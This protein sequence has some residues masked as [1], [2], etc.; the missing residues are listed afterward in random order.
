LKKLQRTIDHEVDFAGVGINSGEQATITIRPAEPNTGI[1]FVRTDL[2]GRP[3]VPAK[4]ENAGTRPFRTSLVKDGVEVQMVEH[5][6]AAFAGMNIH[7][8]I[9]EINAPEV[10]CGDGSAAVFCEMLKNAGAVEQPHPRPQCTVT[11]PICVRDGDASITAIPGEEGITI[12]YTLS[13]P[14]SAIP[15]QHFQISLNGA[16]FGAEIA[17]AR[18]FVLASQVEEL[19]LRGMG[20]GATHDN[21]LVVDEGGVVD[22]ELRFA[23]EF[24]RHKV[25]DV[26]GDLYLLGAQLNAYIVAVKSGHALNRK[27]VEQ[28]RRTMEEERGTRNVETF[29]IRE[30]LQILPHRHPFLFVDRVLELEGDRRAVGIKNLTFNEPFFQ[31]H[32]PG[33]PVMPGVLQIEAMA[34]L[35]GFL[36]LRKYDVGKKLAYLFSLDKVK[37]RRPVVPGDRLLLE[38]ESVRFRH[39]IA[40]IVTKAS[41][42]GE[43]T[44]EAEIKFMIV[45]AT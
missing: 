34:Q 41:V 37:L 17:P 32:W 45:D 1:T 42:D 11:D 28:L 16:N 36:L 12:A 26:V 27:L 31:G 24:A 21:M 10:P 2:P 25:L 23:D 18:T 40:H 6:M 5:L 38:A 30:I 33:Q 44:A 3:E 9:V 35:A 39:R 20:R 8:A 19:Q 14:S 15:S 13:Y 7:N 43:I 4:I 29:D 22:N